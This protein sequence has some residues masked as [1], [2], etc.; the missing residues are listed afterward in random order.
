MKRSSFW[1]TL[2]MALVGLGCLG[3][4]VDWITRDW[5]ECGAGHHMRPGEL[6]TSRTGRYGTAT[7]TLDYEKQAQTQKRVG[8]VG[9]GFGVFILVCAGFSFWTIWRDR[10]GEDAD[11]SRAAGQP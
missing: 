9:V 3:F 5:V 11:R 4:G 2:L 6:C 10:G 8:Y 1:L 7:I